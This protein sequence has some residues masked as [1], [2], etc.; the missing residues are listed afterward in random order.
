MALKATIRKVDLSVAD[1]DRHYYADHSL[2]IAQHPSEN[3]E[4]MMTRILAFSLY[5]SDTLQFTKGLSTDDEPDLWQK[6]YSEEIEHWIDLGQPDEKRIRKACGRSKQ[7]S[8]ICYSGHSAEI[9]WQQQADKCQRFDNLSVINLPSPASS[10][11]GALCDRSMT[12]SA[13]IQDGQVFF[14][15]GDNSIEIQPEVWK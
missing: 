7:V 13:N 9:W 5:A 3:S 2:T 15:N 8:I 10:D 14:S 12:L 6:N 4:R 1:M 11:L